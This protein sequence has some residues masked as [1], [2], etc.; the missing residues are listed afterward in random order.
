MNRNNDLA[1]PGEQVAAKVLR[2]HEDGGWILANVLDF[3]F[4]TQTFEV[5]DEDDITRIATLP[6]CDVRRLD[7]TAVHF[8]KNDKVLAVFPDTTSFYRGVIVKNPKPPS[9]NS[10]NWE[11]IVRFD[12]DEDESGR[13]PPRRIPARFVIYENPEYES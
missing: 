5:Q 1:R 10:A 13:A 2:S 7:D 12:D 4:H 3:D 6:V 8:R 9:T 11:V